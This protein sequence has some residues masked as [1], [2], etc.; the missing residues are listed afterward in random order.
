[1]PAPAALVTLAQAKAHLNITLP[2]GD[3]GDTELQDLLD[4]AESVILTYLTDAPDRA[5]W[6]DPTTTP[7]PVVAAIKLMLGQLYIHRG[8]D[9]ADGEAFWRRIDLLLAQIH[10]P[11]VA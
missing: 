1:M 4:T 10:P 7:G 5:T 6:V 9:E 11:A 3:P 2:D 8:D